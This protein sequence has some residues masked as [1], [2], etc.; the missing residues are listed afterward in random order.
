MPSKLIPGLVYVVRSGKHVKIGWTSDLVGR[1]ASLQTGSPHQLV[2]LGT[3]EGTK[4]LERAWQRE[5]ASARTSGEWFRLN[6]EQMETLLARLAGEPRRM[7][8]PTVMDKGRLQGEPEPKPKRRYRG[9]NKRSRQAQ[10]R[11]DKARNANPT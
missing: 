11:R 7:R 3:R 5:F 8:L 4:A 10:S 9:P 2:L 6:E 1:M